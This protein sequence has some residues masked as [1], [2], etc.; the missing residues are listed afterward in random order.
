M[1]DSDNEVR[2]TLPG[3][4]GGRWVT[5]L[6]VQSLSCAELLHSATYEEKGPW[7]NER[8]VLINFRS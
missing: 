6:H 2:T 5:D 4:D 7:L 3:R 8:S 1:L